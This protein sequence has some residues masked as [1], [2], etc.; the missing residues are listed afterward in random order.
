M[1]LTLDLNDVQ[2]YRRFL[3]IKRLPVY[4]FI[5]RNAWFPDEYA[6][7]IGVVAPR[8]VDFECITHPDAF[9]Y[10]AAITPIAFRKERFACF[11]DCGLGKTLIMLD[12]IRN[13]Q[14]S[15]DAGDKI[16]IVSPLM[17][18]EQTLAECERFFNGE[19]KIEWLRSGKLQDWIERGTSQIAIV[20]YEA[21][22][23]DE[24]LKRG[25]IAAIAADETS[26]L[27]SHYGHYGTKLIELGK[28][29]RWKLALTG[30]PAPNDRIEYANHA[31]FLDQFPTVNSFLARYFVNK[32]QT[33]E[34]WVMRGHAVDRFYHDLSHWSIFLSDPRVYGWRDNC[35]VIPPINVHIVELDM[36]EGQEHEV[37]R[38]TGN[39]VPVAAGGI[40]SR[41]KLSQISKGQIDGRKFATHKPEW[42]RS[43]VAEFESHG[44]QSIVWCKFNPEQ[45]QMRSM[46]PGCANIDGSTPHDERMRLIRAYQRGEI[47]TLVS[48]PRILGMGLNLQC[49]RHHVF[50]TLQDSYEEYYQAIKRSN[51]VRSTEPLDVWIPLTEVERPMVENVL[52]KASKVQEDTRT[53]ERIFSDARK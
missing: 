5:G 3:S 35:G 17:V 49:A 20:N 1:E 15:I 18:I 9:D 6:E 29:V 31:V 2:D 23:G 53:Q 28:G 44:Q 8:R 27:K 24:E 45:D 40:V 41:A 25:R 4:R 14:R 16:L 52:Q 22:K 38:V 37:R 10:Q 50:S 13:V 12:W 19:L 36:T 47:K 7:R 33:S 21:F 46:L 26:M 11:I 42:I 48:K 32:G 39:L 51:R 30:T 34:R 43:K